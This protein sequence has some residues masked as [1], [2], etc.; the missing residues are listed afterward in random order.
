MLVSLSRR[1]F[2]NPNRT[3]PS[4]AAEMTPNGVAAETHVA[5]DSA[6]TLKSDT[7]RRMIQRGRRGEYERERARKC[8]TR[9]HMKVNLRQ[10]SPRG[11]IRTTR[12]S[13]Y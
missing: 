8:N 2:R 4:P 12:D 10:I 3:T 5:P 11:A 9:L 1:M 13:Q 7:W 6:S